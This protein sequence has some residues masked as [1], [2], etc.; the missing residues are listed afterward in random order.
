M[1][2]QVQSNHVKTSSQTAGLTADASLSICPLTHY[3]YKI[4]CQRT[5]YQYTNHKL[6]RRG[7]KHIPVNYQETRLLPTTGNILYSVHAYLMHTCTCTRTCVGVGIYKPQY[8]D[9]MRKYY[10]KKSYSICRSR[11]HVTLQYK[12]GIPTCT[13]K[14][15]FPLKP[16]P[17]C[18]VYTIHDLLPFIIFNFFFFFFWSFCT[19]G[20]GETPLIEGI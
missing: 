19:H 16:S 2:L 7:K 14:R 4:E 17:S 1:K 5:V 6:K 3:T 20:E 13:F 15:E 12:L 8:V 11:V 10:L 9:V 18:D